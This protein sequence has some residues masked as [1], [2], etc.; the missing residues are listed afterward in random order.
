MLA[1]PASEDA[2]RCAVAIQR[3]FADYNQAHAHQPVH[4]RIGLHT[5]EAIADA[6]EFF[7][8]TVILAAQIAA[9]A[10]GGEIVVSQV[11]RDAW[12]SGDNG[13]GAVTFV[14]PRDVELKG[15]SEPQRICSVEWR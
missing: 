3:A 4:V 11:V 13:P 9:Q 7:A 15:I 6:E 2:L 10:R 5:G 14:E 8:L 1:F 12:E